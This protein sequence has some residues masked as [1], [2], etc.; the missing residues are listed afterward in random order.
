MDIDFPI[1]DSIDNLPIFMND[2][3]YDMDISTDY[4]YQAC[5][6]FNDTF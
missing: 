3:E 6:I 2:N 1:N 4:S 5:K